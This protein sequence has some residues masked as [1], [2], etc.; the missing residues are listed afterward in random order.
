MTSPVSAVEAIEKA[1]NRVQGMVRSIDQY[2]NGDPKAVAAGSHAQILFALEDLRHDVLVLWDFANTL[3]RQAEALELRAEA[4]ETL[5]ERLKREAQFHA[6]EARTANSTIYEIYQVV[7]GG[8]GE[9]GNWHGAEPV[10]AKL[11]ALERENAELR[12]ALKPFA[13]HQTADG[14]RGPDSLLYIPDDHPLLFNGLGN[15]IRVTVTVGHIRRAR[16]LLG[17]SDAGN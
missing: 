16:A 4:A 3:A 9:P 17:G 14:L 15:N 7:S 8:K 13:A 11:E 6:Q 10:R 1:P 2:R 12:E 5:A